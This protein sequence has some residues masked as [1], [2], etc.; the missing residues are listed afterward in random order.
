MSH[1]PGVKTSCSLTLLTS[2]PLL[3]SVDVA[4]TIAIKNVDLV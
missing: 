3:N 4:T 2:M 1:Q